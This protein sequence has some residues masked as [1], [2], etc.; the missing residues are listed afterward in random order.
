M[1]EVEGRKLGIR[2]RCYIASK[3]TVRH[4]ILSTQPSSGHIT[5]IKIYI[6]KV[7]KQEENPANTL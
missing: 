6:K 5:R 3:S 7:E 1:C 2:K 4:K